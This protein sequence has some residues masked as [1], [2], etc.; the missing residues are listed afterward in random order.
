MKKDIALPALAVAGGAAGFFL[1]RW[2]LA[3][4]YQPDTEL[5]ISG[6]PATYALLGLTALLALAFLLLLREKQEGVDDFLPAFGSPDVGQMTVLAIA[7]LLMF[8][9]GNFG[10]Q[11]GFRGFR[12]WRA[13]PELYQFSIP[14]SQMLAGG[15]CILGGFGVLFMGRMAYRWEL[16]DA[17]C[18]LASFPAFAGLL[19]LF[20]LHL[21]HGTEPVLMKYGFALFA[22]LLLTL[23]HYYAAG[24]L[25]GRPRP[26]RTAFCALL[27]AVLGLTSLADRHSW[28]DSAAALAFTL[29]ALAL[30]HALL[31]GPWP[32]RTPHE[33]AEHGA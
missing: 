11:A 6:A 16:N 21:R 9:A 31:A 24:F 14:V 30:A 12:L 2:Q 29:S 10:M 13:A 25:F 26:R 7:W 17:A 4:A 23:A 33:D 3:S 15:L 1:R 19:W 28:F 22:A 27:G 32:E 5:F 20:S 8:A 18:H